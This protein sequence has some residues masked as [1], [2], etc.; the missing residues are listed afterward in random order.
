MLTFF[1]GCTVAQA[2]RSIINSSMQVFFMQV[3]SYKGQQ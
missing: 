1:T 3:F 2:D